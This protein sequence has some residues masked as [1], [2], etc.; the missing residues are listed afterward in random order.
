MAKIT[1]KVDAMVWVEENG[2]PEVGAFSEKKD[3]QKF[4][5][6]LPTEF[7]EDWCEQCQLE[8]KPCDNDSIHRMRVAMAILELHFPSEKKST[9]SKSKYSNLTDEDLLK[10]CIDNAVAVEESTHKGIMRMR[11]VQALRANKIIQ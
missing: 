10:M 1:G 11:M 4:Y 7:L 5:K 3:I 9:T 6:Q 8:Y 2:Y